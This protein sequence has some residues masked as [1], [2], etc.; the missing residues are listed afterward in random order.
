MSRSLCALLALPLCVSCL[1][2]PEDGRPEVAIG[3]LAAS[4]FN[5]RGMTNVDAP[6]LQTEAVIDLP[7]KA[8]SGFVSVK[9]WANW[10]LENDTGDAWF[11]DGHAGEPSQI[12]LHLTYSE[13]YRGTDFT[14]GLVSYALQNGDDFPR[15]P[16]GERGETKEVF[17]RAARE[18]VWNLVPSLILHYDF[19][20]VEGWYWNAAVSRDFPINDDFL[21]DSR[22]SLGYA[23]DDQADWLYGLDDG[24]LAD[25]QL[26]AG[27]LYLMDLNTTIRLGLNYST[28]V[29]S[30]ISD[31]FDV[32]GIDPDTFWADLGVT[33]AY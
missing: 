2:V 18:T 16:S 4:Q 8:E 31:W 20:E 14:T 9:A 12:D 6:V 17:V 27:L 1:I 11:P 15:A 32:I 26:R 21:I 5:F 23:D 28:I 24:G 25:L 10:D 3:A 13:K 33:W 22:I 19:D 7:T 29:D 30:D